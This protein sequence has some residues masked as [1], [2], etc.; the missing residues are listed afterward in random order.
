MASLFGQILLHLHRP[1]P[2][3]T[4]DDPLSPFWKRHRALNQ[5][6]SKITLSL[7]YTFKL[8]NNL[9]DG[10]VVFTNL[11]IHAAT[12][13]LHQ[14]SIFKGR[15]LESTTNT[16]IVKDSE[17]RCLS[18]ACEI[19]SI[20][21]MTSH[22]DITI[23]MFPGLCPSKFLT[24]QMH[25]FLSFCVY[26]G[27]RVFI[28]YLKNNP[29]DEN[30]YS[31]LEFLNDVL[32]NLKKL[33]PLTESFIVQLEVDIGAD[34]DNPTHGSRFPYSLR[35]GQVRHPHVNEYP[36]VLIR[37]EQ[38]EMYSGQN[39]APNSESSRHSEEPYPPVHEL[40]KVF[41]HANV[42]FDWVAQGKRPTNEQ[43]DTAE[44]AA[45]PKRSGLGA[46]RSTDPKQRFPGPLANPPEI[47]PRDACGIHF[48]T[49]DK[50][51]CGIMA[52][53]SNTSTGANSPGAPSGSSVS[54]SVSR[55]SPSASSTGHDFQGNSPSSSTAAQMAMP[56]FEGTKDAASSFSAA[57][58]AQMLS[59]EFSRDM[60][61]PDWGAMDFDGAYMP[62][63]TNET[64]Y[65]VNSFY[66]QQPQ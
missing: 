25:P 19:A 59:D 27:A 55:P 54:G 50:S 43:L 48:F 15:K 21:R 34:L 35:K 66:P 64:S 22:L 51:G 5:L 47:N 11:N 28:Q 13:C 42:A 44:A 56:G 6:L 52:R 31:Q 20:M 45:S 29:Q 18:A 49:H 61:L 8:P 32:K 7:P 16:S 24:S 26:V 4:P 1:E 53:D 62:V 2:G 58:Y 12:I 60:Q 9:R 57:M 30:I 65:D 41:H 40:P 38:A 33:N 14:A 63:E 36:A 3:E 23:V 37:D 10:N 17:I 39:G 46:S